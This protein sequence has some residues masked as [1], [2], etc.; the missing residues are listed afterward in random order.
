MLTSTSEPWSDLAPFYLVLTAVVG[1]FWLM[2]DLARF[3]RNRSGSFAELALLPG[4]GNAGSQRR[5]LYRAVLV[6]PLLLVACCL[7]GGMLAAWLAWH[8]PERLMRFGL[9]C[10]VLLLFCATAVLQLL[11]TKSATPTRIAVLGQSIV[12]LILAPTLLQT[13]PSEAWFSHPGAQRLFIIFMLILIAVQLCL[14]WVS[15][16]GLARR[17]HPFLEM[18]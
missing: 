10:V 17:S 13:L 3:V 16:Q 18:S 8:S 7:G 1:W 2:T 4:L 6:R 12:P 5:A 11:N 15:T 14:I 9:G